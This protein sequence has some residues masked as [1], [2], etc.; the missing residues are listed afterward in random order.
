MQD[1]LNI[2]EKHPVYKFGIGNK[3]TLVTKIEEQGIDLRQELIEFH[4]RYYSGNIMKLVVLGKENLS[5]LY[6]YVMKYYEDIPTNES[7]SIPK[8]P[9]L[10]FGTQLSKRAY[11]IPVR[12]ETTKL[13]LNFPAR[14]VM[15]FYNCKPFSYISHLIGHEGNGSILSLLKKLG[16]ANELSA[17]ESHDAS[18]WAIFNISVEMTKLGLERVEDVVDIIFAYINLLNEED[19]QEW[20]FEETKNVANCRFRFLSKR[21]PIDYTCTLSTAMHLYPEDHIIAGM[22]K[23][24][25][26]DADVI[27]EVSF[28]PYFAFN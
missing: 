7:I 19:A 16:Y 28:L 13:E 20:V 17:G 5:T 23:I 26:Y 24:Y 11:M 6:N 8:F 3:E 12:K 2:K 9:G 1:E 10:P 27:R 22:Y 4:K 21:N 14:E 18:D 25:S 15:S